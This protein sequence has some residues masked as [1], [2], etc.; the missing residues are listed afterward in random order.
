[1]S[2]LAPFGGTVYVPS[3]IVGL[4]FGW[5][6]PNVVEFDDEDVFIQCYPLMKTLVRCANVCVYWNNI[7]KKIPVYKEVI[8]AITIRRFI[9][10]GYFQDFADCMNSIIGNYR[11][12]IETHERLRSLITR[13]NKLYKLYHEHSRIDIPIGALYNEIVEFS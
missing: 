9:I 7:V 5:L 2:L 12:T 11:H 10:K 8:R 6:T 3:D 1:M 4:I 13:Y